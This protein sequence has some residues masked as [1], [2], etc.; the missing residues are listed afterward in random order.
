MCRQIGKNL[1]ARTGVSHVG[2]APCPFTT[3]VERVPGGSQIGSGRWSIAVLAETVADVS[4]AVPNRTEQIA[5]V[6][7]GG[8]LP[9]ALYYE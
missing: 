3:W 5:K 4:L 7:F 8:S 6:V 1:V 9:A 2:I